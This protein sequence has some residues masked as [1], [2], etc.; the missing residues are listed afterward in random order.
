MVNSI[1]SSEFE[2]LDEVLSVVNLQDKDVLDAGAGARS[3]RF[4]A[5]RNP[6]KIVCIVGPGD[7]RKEEEARDRLRSMGCEDY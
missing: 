3:V 2:L 7:I 1:V 4:L 6:G 5:L